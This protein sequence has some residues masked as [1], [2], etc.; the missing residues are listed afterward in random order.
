MKKQNLIFCIFLLL[1]ASSLNAQVTSYPFTEGFEGTTFPP[2]NWTQDTVSGSSGWT[3][4]NGNQN[5]LTAKTGSLNA[6]FYVASTTG[7][8]TRLIT[9]AMNLSSVT[10]PR[11]VFHHTQE[12]WSGDQDTLA[13][14][15]KTS[16]S[17]SWVLLASYSNS[18]SSWTERIITL[19]NKSSDY[20]VS[21]EAYG[22][23]GYGITLD[24]FKVE[25]TPSCLTPTSLV[26]SGISTD[27][28]NLGWTQ[29]GTVSTW[30]IEWD[31][32]N[33]VQGTGNLVVSSTN[34]YSLSS[35]SA[36]TAYD[37]YVRAICG[38]S[39]TSAWSSKGSF[40][41]NCNAFAIP[42]NEGFES[43]YTHNTNVAG[44]IDQESTTG[45]Q[46]WTANNTLTTY[47]RT[48][49]TG[50]WN[51][52]L[53]YG[54][55][56]W[57]FIPVDLTSG[58]SYT[59]EVWA[60]QDGTTTT[61]S[62]V[63]IRYGTSPSAAAMSDTIVA[64]TGITNTA[65]LITGE[66][67]PTTSGVYYI[68]I[69]GYMN[70]SPW[71]ISIDDIAIIETPSCL[72]PTSGLASDIATDS[73]NLGWTENGTAT[74]WQ[75]E[76]DTANFVQG[77]GNLVISSTNPYTI[78]SL[79]ANTAYDFYVRAICG[80]GDTSAWSDKASFTTNCNAFSVP[81]TEGFESGYV[82]NTSVEGCLD[83]EST[84]GTQ[85]W[86][87]NNTLTTYN[88]SPRTGNWN[89]FL[90]YSND[91]WLFIPMDL[92]GGTTYTAEVWAKQ[93]GSTTTNSDVGIKYGSS[94]SAASM[95][96]TIVANTG[97]DNVSKLIKGAFTPATSGTYYVGINGYMNGSPWYISIDDIAITECI[98]TTS[99]DVHTACDSFTWTNGITYMTSNNVA[100]DTFVNE[101]G[102][103]SIVTLDLT[104][105]NSSSRTDV[106]T[107]CNIFTW[108]NGMTYTASNNTAMDTFTNAA[109]C[110]SVVT[111]DLTI[112]SNDLTI[113]NSDPVLEVSE[114]TGAEYQWLNCTENY[115]IIEGETQASFKART[116]NEYAVEITNSGCIDTSSCQAITLAS[117]FE[118]A[119]F[120]GVSIYPNPNTGLVNIDLGLLNN[121]NISVYDL[122][123]AVIYTKR[124]IESGLFQFTLD[125]AN[126]I[127]IVEITSNNQTLR[128]R[129]IKQ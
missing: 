40:T 39:D 51:A 53:R 103:D 5:A 43:G 91:D 87:A 84:T 14:Y 117:V 62:N 30:Q 95:T 104:I 100:M 29:G 83:Q 69:N 67:T 63:G 56:D 41:T 18:I 124:S 20:Y 4:S 12:D 35:L 105:L 59:A 109:G 111:L 37:F 2:S 75:I 66:F 50:S 57:L 97:I 70:S 33:F 71:Y 8:T 28:A 11:L 76:W 86:T 74:S 80:T 1:F 38:T 25:A 19:P 61:N 73:A 118:S 23:Y 26:V 114:Q 85:T 98:T 24:D 49:R 72:T 127:Y 96:N 34:P 64:N 92:V 17:G 65:T 102:C 44:C 99:T 46:T 13:V 81:Y 77:T 125:A 101:A 21:F 36:N 123:G 120:D 22:S 106:Q 54:N 15:Y 78:S 60:N 7:S 10:N 6:L 3:S 129:L 112:I 58:T 32:A 116:N 16:A 31:T 113:T 89:A 48:P 115:A 128:S 126:G 9:P 79:S 45:A 52:F 88:R 82:H 93:D 107:A 42:Y 90:R 122:T 68:G 121:V 27:S 110:D 94:A 55:D 47:S 119:I 108:T